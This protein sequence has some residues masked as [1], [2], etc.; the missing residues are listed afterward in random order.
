[1]LRT[2]IKE[3]EP[4]KNGRVYSTGV[5]AKIKE[6]LQP[7]IDKKICWVVLGSDRD[8]FITACASDIQDLF[9]ER[10]FGL[11]AGLVK[12]FFIENGEGILDI[13]ILPTAVGDNLKTYLE[14]GV[15]FRVDFDIKISLIEHTDDGLP[16]ITPE[17][18]IEVIPV[19]SLRKYEG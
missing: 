9:T 6:S 1:M 16:L 17:N 7:Y 10:A 5:M 13:E 2:I 19:V 11:Y 15:D 14:L 18:I 12:G 8:V 3:G 4:T